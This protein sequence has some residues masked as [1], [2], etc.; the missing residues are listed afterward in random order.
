MTA[1]RITVLNVERDRALRLPPEA[2]AGPHLDAR[3]LASAGA[4]RVAALAEADGYLNV[5]L[6]E[7]ARAEAAGGRRLMSAAA[8]I[9]GIDRITLIRHRNRRHGATQ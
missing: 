3:L 6:D 1:S 5:V 8:R 7:V 2:G 9:S 4:E